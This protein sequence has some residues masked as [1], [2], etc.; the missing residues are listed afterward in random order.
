MNCNFTRKGG[1]QSADV[2]KA[3][4]HEHNFAR[5]PGKS[6]LGA[7]RLTLRIA[8]SCPIRTAR[9]RTAASVSIL[10]CRPAASL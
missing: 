8:L 7:R 2:L 5:A 4:L 6:P 3:F 10:W 9:R 1:S